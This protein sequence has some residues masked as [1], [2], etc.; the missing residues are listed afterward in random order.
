MSGVSLFFWRG[1]NLIL[2]KLLKI[3][4][5]PKRQLFESHTSDLL[6]QE[7]N[8]GDLVLQ[9]TC[10][11]EG[12]SFSGPSQIVKSVEIPYLFYAD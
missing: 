4:N 9:L 11:P 3:A 1:V 2:L 12:C 10:C 8:P 7:T 5:P 6:C